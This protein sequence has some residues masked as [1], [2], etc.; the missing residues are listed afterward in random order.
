MMQP[1]FLNDQIILKAVDRQYW[2]ALWHIHDACH[3]VTENV[4]RVKVVGSV[5]LRVVSQALSSFT[6]YTGNP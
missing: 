1:E 5:E 3:V 4:N 6:R 2:Y